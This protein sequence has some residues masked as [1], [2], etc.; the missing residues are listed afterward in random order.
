M[1][2]EDNNFEDDLQD[3]VD[4]I[5]ERKYEESTRISY[6]ARNAQFVAFLQRLN[7]HD[8][9]LSG[10]TFDAEKVDLRHMELFLAHKLNEGLTTNALKV[11]LPSPI[12]HL[13]SSL[14]LRIIERP[15]HLAFARPACPSQASGMRNSDS[16]ILALRNKQ[17]QRCNKAL[18]PSSLASSPFHTVFI[19]GYVGILFALG[20]S[21]PGLT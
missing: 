20:I 5:N 17:R 18:V 7:L 19:P 1:E 4:A 3:L 11:R 12:P 16:S 2:N 9:V 13:I 21:L 8:L 14:L 6:L 10:N 15:L